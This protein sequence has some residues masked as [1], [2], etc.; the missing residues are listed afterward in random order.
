MFNAIV[1]W[2]DE[3]DPLYEYWVEYTYLDAKRHDVHKAVGYVRA[4][5]DQEAYEIVVK[6]V[7]R[8]I[9]ID[10]VKRTPLA[11]PDRGM[12][13]TELMDAQG[14]PKVEHDKAAILEHLEAPQKP[15][16]WVTPSSVHHAKPTVIRDGLT[17]CDAADREDWAAFVALL[18]EH[19]GWKATWEYPGF[20]S[21][22]RKGLQAEVVA[23]PDWDSGEYDEIVCDF[24]GEDGER[25][26][27]FGRPEM[28]REFVEQGIIPWPR[29][30]RS[31]ESYM[32]LVTKKLDAVDAHVSVYRETARRLLV[33]A[34]FE[35]EGDFEL[36]SDVFC[37]IDEERPG[38][39]I[40]VQLWVDQR[41]AFPTDETTEQPK[42][43]G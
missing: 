17:G 31:V 37:P 13:T 29:D 25:F 40:S 2:L 1:A 34:R 22:K 9:K 6:G 28:E 12:T 19:N 39:W 38:A 4:K 3:N 30:E 32:A 14:F 21:W 24:R 8:P 36:T 20:V 43:E 5:T 41:D 15:I 33:D 27:K 18:P 35:E 11:P 26:A 10:S 42:Q 23:T 7:S 16:V